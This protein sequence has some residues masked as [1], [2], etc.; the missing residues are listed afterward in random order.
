M[1]NGDFTFIQIKITI[2]NKLSSWSSIDFS[3]EINLLECFRKKN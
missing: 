3:Y 2:H 1:N